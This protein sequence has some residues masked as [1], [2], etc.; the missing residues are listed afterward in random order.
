MSFLREPW[1]TNDTEITTQ[2]RDGKPSWAAD[3][4]PAHKIFTANATGYNPCVRG[5]YLSFRYAW[6]TAEDDFEIS[7]PLYFFVNVPINRRFPS[8]SR[9]SL[10][11]KII[12]VAVI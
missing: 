10:R 3:L 9:L 5:G 2:I 12:W 7:T 6:P 8:S 11:N 4:T 1:H